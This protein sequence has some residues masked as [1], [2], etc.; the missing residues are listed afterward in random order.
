MPDYLLDSNHASPLVTEGHPLRT[1]VL[2][3][4]RTGSTFAIAAPCVVVRR[5]DR[6]LLTIDG[7]FAGVPNLRVENWLAP[8]EG[9]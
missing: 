8:Q 1:R 5:Y 7:D 9:G 6:I 2:E 3:A 4:M